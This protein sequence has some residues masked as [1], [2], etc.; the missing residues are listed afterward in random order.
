IKPYLFGDVVKPEENRLLAQHAAFMNGGA[1]IYVPRN[2]HLELPLQAVFTIDTVNTGLYN[3][4][5]IVDEDNSSL[6]YVE[7][8]VSQIEGEAV[9]NI[10]AEVYAGAG[11]KVAFGA[12]D[13]LSSEIT[14]YVVRRGHVGKDARIDWA[15]GQMND[16]STVSDN[17]THL[18]GD[19]S[20]ADAKT[21][22]IG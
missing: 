10:V 2:V 12:V 20:W 4:V 1:F 8:Y 22:T 6:T 21:V 16:G 15:L 5:V 3:H 19:G 7:N 17:T 9:A 13:N 14:T 18:V 11:A